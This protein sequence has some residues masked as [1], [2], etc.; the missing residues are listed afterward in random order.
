MKTEAEDNEESSC[1][2]KYWGQC[3]GHKSQRA[4]NFSNNHQNWK[5]RS[6]LPF[7]SK[8]IST[9][10]VGTWDLQPSDFYVFSFLIEAKNTVSLTCICMNQALTRNTLSPLRFLS[11]FFPS[12]L[13]CPLHSLSFP[14]SLIFFFISCILHMCSVFYTWSNSMPLN[15]NI[16]KNV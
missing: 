5:G 3:D 10:S 4:V 6:K 14:R 8:G 1:Q 15:Y 16:N 12:F 7:S 2:D 11:F 9:V 13:P